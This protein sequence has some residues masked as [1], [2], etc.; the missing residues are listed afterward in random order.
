[1]ITITTLIK[2]SNQ[3]VRAFLSK[4]SPPLQ[5]SRKI[6]CLLPSSLKRNTSVYIGVY[7]PCP[8]GR[9]KY[10][11]LGKTMKTGKIKRKNEKEKEE[12]K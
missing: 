5:Y 3:Q 12:E 2:R 1:M 11:T 7:T 9:E 6:N 10:G 8:P 4:S